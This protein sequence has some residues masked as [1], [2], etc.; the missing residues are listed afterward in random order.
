[1]NRS[2]CSIPCFEWVAAF[3]YISL[4]GGMYVYDLGGRII[5]SVSDAG[6]CS[7][8]FAHCSDLQQGPSQRTLTR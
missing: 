5:L 7:F 3:A 2:D 4:S 6:N 1:M 8:L